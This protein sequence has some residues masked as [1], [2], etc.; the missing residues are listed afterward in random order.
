MDLLLLKVISSLNHIVLNHRMAKAQRQV[1][2]PDPDERKLPLC[3]KNL[4]SPTIQLHRRVTIPDSVACL[5][6]S[7]CR[8]RY[9]KAFQ[10]E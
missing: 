8:R 6:D 3:F 1:K 10:D 5:L 4:L 7:D 9:Q 2:S